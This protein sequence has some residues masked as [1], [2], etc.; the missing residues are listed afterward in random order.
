MKVLYCGLK[1]DYGDQSRGYSFEHLNFFNTFKNMKSITK[2]DYICLDD[3]N[4]NRLNQKII[5]IAKIIIM[6]LYFSFYLKM[7]FFPKH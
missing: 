2:L 1:F 3:Y 5:E 4:K 7:K 6:I